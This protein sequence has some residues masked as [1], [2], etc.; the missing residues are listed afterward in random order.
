MTSHLPGGGKPW[1][2]R[3][4][5][6]NGHDVRPASAAG[7]VLTA[8]FVAGAAL[9]S[10]ALLGGT[11]GLSQWLIWSAVM[12]IGTTLFVVTMLRTSVLEADGRRHHGHQRAHRGS[13]PHR[14]EG[15]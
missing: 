8:S 10:V 3:K 5:S 2:V 9:V 11:P 4:R 6:R 13:R 15:K 14:E 12:T 7:W 1:F